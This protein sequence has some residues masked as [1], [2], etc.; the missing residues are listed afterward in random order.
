MRIILWI[1][2]VIV[3]IFIIALIGLN[4]YFTDERLQNMIMPQLE[5]T[6]GREVTVE[7]MS[8]SFFRTFPN[9]GLIAD[10]I[11]VPDDQGATLASLEQMVIAINVIP[12][13]TDNEVRV[14]QLDLEQPEMM[15]IVYEDG[16][17]NVD[18]LLAHMEAEEQPTEEEPVDFD[19]QHISINNAR[20]SYDDRV[21]GNRVM[22]GGLNAESAIRFAEQLQTDIGVDIRNISFHQQEEEMVSGLSLSF[23]TEAGI[24]FE[25]EIATIDSGSLNLSGL[26]LT[27]AGSISEW[28]AENMMVDLVF[29][30]E[31]DDFAALLDLVPEAYD[32]QLE[33]VETDG[34]LS[35]AGTVAGHAGSETIPGFQFVFSVDD[36]YLKYPD[37]E[38]PIEE[39]S[40]QIEASNDVINLQRFGALAGVNQ[41]SAFGE[42]RQPL[43]DIARFAL[44]MEVDVD[45]STVKNFYPLEEKG[46]ELAGMLNVKAVGEGLLQD[47]ENAN[48]DSEIILGDGYVLMPDV[49]EPIHDINIAMLMSQAR[50]EIQSF[51]A[52]AA[53]NMLDI[54]GTIQDPLVEDQASFDLFADLDLDLATIKSFYPI[55]EDTLMLRG[56][57]TA[58]GTAQGNINDAENANTDLEVVLAN[59]FIHHRDLPHPL[60]D[61]ELESTVNHNFLDITR[62]SLRSGNNSFEGSGRISDY[63]GDSPAVDITMETEFDLAEAGDYFDMQEY[64]L[65]LAGNLLADLQVNGPVDYPEDL[66]LTGNVNLNN[67]HIAG[68]ELM[69]PITDLNATLIFSED[70]ADLEEFTMYMGES[71]FQIDA[72]LSNYMA[73]TAEVGQVEPA[74]LSGT[75]HSRKLNLDELYDDADEPDEPFPIE[76]PNLVT[77]LTA[78][79]DTMVFMGM[80]ATNIN[81]RAESDPTTITM[82]EGSLNMFG[83]SISGSFVWNVPDPENTNITFQGSLEN[84]RAE[85]FFEEY[86]LG[87]RIQLHEYAKG[88]FSAE[89]EYFTELDVYLNPVI[90][91][92]QSTGSFGM[93]EA[94]LHNHPIQTAVSS[95]LNAEE[96]QDLSL[97]EWTANYSIDESI[98]SLENVNITSQDIGLNMAGSLNLESDS[99]DFAAQLSLPERFADNLGGIITGQGAE[100][101]KNDDGML[102]IPFSIGGTSEDPR[103]SLDEGRIEDLLADYLRGR[104]GEEGREAARGI[105]NRLRDN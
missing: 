65:T 93:D 43:E 42:L 87:G 23:E 45:L 27:L 62:A 86:Q 49:E 105:L 29:A 54:S 94:E 78:S 92:T 55:D 80:T 82:P 88:N 99:L 50:A 18:E 16:R 90:P 7:N 9:F 39:I 21:T 24:N 61:F 76:L 84:L 91:S 95:L 28:S 103:P 36:G 104:A 22:L 66:I 68:G 14:I 71:D 75:Y 10:N 74:V 46:I 53:G 15:Y 64:Q 19:M 20:L 72:G 2:G 70:R 38:D 97:D 6:A 41:V 34:A 85:D 81:G 17:S 26:A 57:L 96:L 11:L 48:F 1:A 67:I 4:I 32:E 51:S 77:Q 100:A 52:Q 47:P 35:I 79:I 58:S 3:G 37:V 56:Q 63:M 13:F 31:S 44:N 101:L 60:E 59:G 5:E 89:T 98:L 8:F 40:L 102:M 33:G 69:Q 25:D 83:G 73:L 12:Y 30:S